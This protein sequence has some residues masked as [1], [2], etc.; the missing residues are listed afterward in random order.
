MLDTMALD[1]RNSSGSDLNIL[2]PRNSSG[3]YPNIFNRV[4]EYLKGK[5][6]QINDKKEFTNATGSIE[7]SEYEDISYYRFEDKLNKAQS[8]SE[9]LAIIRQY[10]SNNIADRLYELR[11]E[12]IDIE[13][14]E[15]TLS[16][17]SAKCLTYYCW[18]RG[19]TESPIITATFDGLLQIDFFDKDNLISIRFINNKEIIYVDE[20][21]TIPYSKLNL[22]QLIAQQWGE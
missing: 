7:E 15:K 2:D 3:S 5:G 19:I 6:E 9:L 14:G 8:F 11:I 13:E 20:R 22:D 18:M 12:P 21:S 1:P 16:L 4:L 10:L 17:N